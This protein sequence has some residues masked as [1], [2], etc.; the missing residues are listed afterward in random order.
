MAKAPEQRMTG[1][2]R[3]E[4]EQ[5]NRELASGKRG[6][7]GHR[8]T[9]CGGSGRVPGVHKQ[10]GTGMGSNFGACPDCDGTGYVTPP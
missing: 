6:R 5:R 7:S 1:R 8:C 4:R 9:T 2:E 10:R 3:S